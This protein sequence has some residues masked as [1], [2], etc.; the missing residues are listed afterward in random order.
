[1]NRLSENLSKL[2]E[3]KSLCISHVPKYATHTY[4][5]NHD[6]TDA[7]ISIIMTSSNRS[8]QVYY[9][10]ST[11]LH[12]TF[13]DIHVVLVDDSNVDPVSLDNLNKFPFAIDFIQINKAN[14]FWINPCVNYN[15]AFQYI[16]GSKVVLQNSEVC[17]VGDVLS[18]VHTSIK[19]NEYSVFDVHSCN[20]YS[21]NDVIYSIHDALTIEIF[22][23]GIFSWWYQHSIQGNRQLHF[24]SAFT[25]HTF[26]KFKGFSLDY[27]FSADYDD[28]DL[29]LL[30]KSKGINVYSISHETS[31]VGGIHL[32]HTLSG[33]AWTQKTSNESLFHKKNE[34]CAK[35]IGEYLE[36]SEGNT[37][38]ELVHRFNALRESRIL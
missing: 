9:T 7:T 19:D 34:F 24:L 5:N 29:L 37:I 13:K 32:Y 3:V 10:L 31:M 30:I 28:N 36:V 1:M 25:T 16:K 11:F 2:L 35:H 18:Y 26:N 22:K 33:I 15:I 38:E 20:N 12:S 4:V 14:K 17:H 21:S 23:A 6:I 27:A 8:K